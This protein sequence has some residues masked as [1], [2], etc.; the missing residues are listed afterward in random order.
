M[1]ARPGSATLPGTSKVLEF[2]YDEDLADED[3]MLDYWT[4]LQA[5]KA[6]LTKELGEKEA[7]FKESEANHAKFTAEVSK[8]RRNMRRTRTVSPVSFSTPML[9]VE[10]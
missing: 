8:V 1:V 10:P 5:T 6:R 2:L 9:H 4:D 3:V 7:L